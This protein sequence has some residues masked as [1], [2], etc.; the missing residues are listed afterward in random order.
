VR[1]CNL[2]SRCGGIR[3]RQQLTAVTQVFGPPPKSGHATSSLPQHGFARASRWEFLGKSDTEDA[4]ESNSV[5]LDFGLDKSGLSEEARKAWPL[6][7]G[8]VYSVTLS[9]GSLQTVMT[10]RNEGEESFEF[11]FLLH[12]YWKVQ[13]RLLHRHAGWYAN[14]RDRTSPRSASPACPAPSTLTRSSTRPHTSKRTTPSRSPAKLTAS[15]RRSHKTQLRSLKT[16]SPALMSSATMSGTR[17][18]GIRGS[19]RPR[20]W[21]TSRPTTATRR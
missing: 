10:V 2:G 15:T 21:A 11:Q 19:R 1:L 9:K 14:R 4:S 18:P 3:F 7:F 17:L 8:L 13:V 16:E 6:D 12:S 20:L 5:K